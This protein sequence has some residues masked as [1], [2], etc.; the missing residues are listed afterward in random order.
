MAIDMYMHASF[1]GAE[2]TLA[3]LTER[4]GWLCRPKKEVAQV[5]ARLSKRWAAACPGSVWPAG[6]FALKLYPTAAHPV[7]AG[8]SWGPPSL[9]DN[10]TVSLALPWIFAETA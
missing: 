2:P 8:A 4:I 3:Q 9:P 7:I 5:L 10:L 6:E 1:L